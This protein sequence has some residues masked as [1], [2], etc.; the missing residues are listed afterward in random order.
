MQVEETNTN[1]PDEIVNPLRSPSFVSWKP[2]PPFFPSPSCFASKYD[3]TKI[4]FHYLIAI[5]VWLSALGL[6]WLCT[7]DSCSVSTALSLSLVNQSD[8]SYFF[9]KPNLTITIYYKEK[10]PHPG[11]K[12]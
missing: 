6:E 8:I 7:P 2:S 9:Q 11:N 3:E 10:A 12:H 5:D 4:L 1:L